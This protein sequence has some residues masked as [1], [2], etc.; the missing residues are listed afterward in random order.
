[1]ASFH[2]WESPWLNF[3]VWGKVAYRYKPIPKWMHLWVMFCKNS[4]D[5]WSLD[6]GIRLF[7]LQL[8]R[9]NNQLSTYWSCHWGHTRLERLELPISMSWIK[10]IKNALIWYATFMCSAC[11]DDVYLLMHLCE[12][13]EVGISLSR[14]FWI[15]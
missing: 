6:Q 3:H 14:I 8:Y 4:E 9:V 13:S 7:C 12:A 11:Y 15:S 10:K 2:L 5:W 1:M